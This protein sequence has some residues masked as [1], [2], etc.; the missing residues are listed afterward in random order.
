MTIQIQN[1]NESIERLNGEVRN[2]KNG[3]TG[4]SQGDSMMDSNSRLKSAKKYSQ[5]SDHGSNDGNIKKDDSFGSLLNG[6]LFSHRSRL[7]TQTNAKCGCL[8]KYNTSK[9]TNITLKKQL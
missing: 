4:Y 7:T 6:S 5:V 8:S 9:N 1:K 3:Q 2:L